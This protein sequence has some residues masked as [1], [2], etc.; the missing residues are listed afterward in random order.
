MH[1]FTAHQDFLKRRHGLGKCVLSPPTLHPLPASTPSLYIITCCFRYV[2]PTM[3]TY[4]G[5]WKEDVR[6]GHGMMT[7]QNGEV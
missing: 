7:F 1:V 4:V 2:W 3:D 6:T 5:E